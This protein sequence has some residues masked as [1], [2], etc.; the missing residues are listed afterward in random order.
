MCD[1]VDVQFNN[2][3]LIEKYAVVNLTF[4]SCQFLEANCIHF[5]YIRKMSRLFHAEFQA[6]TCR[7]LHVDTFFRLPM[8]AYIT[9]IKII[10]FIIFKWFL[11]SC[12]GA[13]VLFQ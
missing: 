12:N 10:I 3:K 13:I 2:V 7:S 9:V 6:Q 4:P 5:V 1:F 8:K 11:K